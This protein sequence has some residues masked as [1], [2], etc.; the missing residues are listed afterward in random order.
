MNDDGLVVMASVVLDFDLLDRVD[1][2]VLTDLVAFVAIF[3]FW[4]LPQ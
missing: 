2:G 1:D 4:M 3:S